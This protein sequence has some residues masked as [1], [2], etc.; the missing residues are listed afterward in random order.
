MNVRGK[1][2]R[3]EGSEKGGV[4]EESFVLK[5]PRNGSEEKIERVKGNMSAGV[6]RGLHISSPTDVLG[7][8]YV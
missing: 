8:C 3:E 5:S 1:E 4:M 7:S 2:S 6:R